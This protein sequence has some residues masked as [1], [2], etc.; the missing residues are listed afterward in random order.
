[1]FYCDPCAG[2]RGW[3]IS[4]QH[5]FGSCEICGQV[6]VCNDV[7]SRDLPTPKPIDLGAPKEQT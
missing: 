6:R 3:P 5:S 1:M 4:W 7:P 2:P